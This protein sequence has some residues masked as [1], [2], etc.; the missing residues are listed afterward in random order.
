MFIPVTCVNFYCCLFYF[1]VLFFNLEGSLVPKILVLIFRLIF[2]VP[3]NLL[4]PAPLNLSWLIPPNL[5]W[6]ASQNFCLLT[7]LN[8]SC[9]A[10]QRPWLLI[11]RQR[12]IPPLLSASNPASGGVPLCCQRSSQRSSCPRDSLSPACV[13]PI[14][15]P[16]ESLS[17]LCLSLELSA[18]G[19]MPLLCSA[20][21][22]LSEV[23]CLNSVL[24]STFG[25]S[26]LSQTLD[27][28]CKV[29]KQQK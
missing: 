29:T 22:C 15:C 13:L 8:V 19:L 5:S 7:S 12:W 28:V 26:V 27:S 16:P 2:S 21:G 24:S 17:F 18:Q 6:T 10:L 1:E 4:C 11:V 23:I 9:P 14:S 25:Q 20:I 3:V